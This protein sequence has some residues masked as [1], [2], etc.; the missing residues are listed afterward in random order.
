MTMTGGLVAARLAA[1]NHPGQ[2]ASSG[3]RP[4]RPCRERLDL[5]KCQ[6]ELAFGYVLDRVLFVPGF[7]RTLTASNL[8]SL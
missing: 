3:G 4:Y 6:R 5:R 8:T 1:P 7:H 2:A